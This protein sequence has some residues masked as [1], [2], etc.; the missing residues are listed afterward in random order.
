MKR[1]HVFVG[2]NYYPSGFKDY[3]G[4]YTTLR[5][6]HTAIGL[7]KWDWWEIIDTMEDGSLRRVEDSC[8]T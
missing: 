4:S 8:E 3:I 5:A 1:F 2:D 7:L 6:A